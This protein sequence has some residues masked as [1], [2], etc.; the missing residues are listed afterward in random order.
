MRAV[1]IKISPFNPATNARVPV[2]LSSLNDKTLA[3]INAMGANIWVPCLTALPTLSIEVFNGDFQAAVQ[4]GNASF[5]FNIAMLAEGYPG[6][7]AMVW[8]RAP[9]EIY[10]EDV[11]AAL[12]WAPRFVGKVESFSLRGLTMTLGAK[13]DEEPFGVDVLTQTYAGTT[14]AEGPA[15]LK[16]KTK[17]LVIGWVQNVEPVLINATDSVYQF[18][19]YGPIEQVTTLYERGAAN[20]GAAVADYANYAALV[21]ASIPRGRWATCLAQGMIRLGAPAYGV[22]TADVKGHRVG[23]TTPRLSGQIISALASI[24]GVSSSLLHTSSLDAMDANKPYPAGLVLTE[25]TNLLDIAQTLALACNHQCG[26]SLL[27]QLFV[28]RPNLAASPALSVNANGSTWPQVA[29]CSEEATSAPYWRT[30]MGA[31]KSWRV[32]N[33]DEV[34]FAANLIP[35]G[36]YDDAET[37]R[38]GNIVDLPDGSR[39][40]YINTSPTAGNDP[41]TWPTASNAWWS[42]HTPPLNAS[43]LAYADGTPIEDLKPADP[44]ATAGADI[45]VDLR[46]PTSIPTAAELVTSLGTA[47]AIAG[48]GDM[49][50][51][52]RSTLAFGDNLVVNSEFALVDPTYS[53]GTTPVGWQP[54]WLG[55]STN[56]GAFTTNP[57]RVTLQDG[58][59]AYARDV[60]GT[61]NGTAMD[62]IS[63]YPTGLPLARFAVPVLPGERL[64]YSALLGYQ[65]CSGAYIVIGFYDENGNYVDE[66]GSTTITPNIGTAAYNTITRSSLVQSANVLTVP[67][68]GSGGGTGKRRWAVIWA[69]YNLNGSA[70]PRLLF[71]APMIAKVMAGQLAIPTY[72]PGPADR[73]ASYGATTGT[74]LVSPTYGNL[75]DSGI[76]TPIGT[77]AAIVG[78][79]PF[80]TTPLPV[81]RLTQIRPNLFPYPQ[82]VD[83]GRSSAAIG[84]FNTA[85]G[86]GFTDLIMG[87][88]SWTDGGYY[89]HYRSSGPAVNLFPFYDM[90]W[91]D[92]GGHVISAGLNGYASGGTFNPYVEFINAAKTTILG[93]AVMT[94]NSASDRWEVN[95]VTTPANTAFIRMVASAIFAATSVYQDVVFWS[96]KVERGPNATPCL[97]TPNQ[98]LSGDQIEWSTGGKLN[99]LRPDELGSNKTE[100]RVASAISGQTGWATYSGDTPSTYQLRVQYIDTSGQLSA[101]DR[102]VDRRMTLLRRADG[103]TALTEAMAITALGTA[104]AIVGQG[105]GA[106]AANLAAFDPTASAQL[107]TAYNGGA[108]TVGLGETLK[109]RL[110]AAA[111][112]D[113]SAQVSVDAGGSSS[114]NI[115]ARIEVSLFGAGSWSTVNTGPG[116]S[117]TP[118][119]PG[120]DE[121]TGT[122]TNSTG[123]E[124]L[125]EFRVVIVRTPGTA[126]G[127]LISAQS[128][129]VG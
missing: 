23:A 92:G 39:W 82:G 74:N 71:A 6:V 7:E 59:Y 99:A 102:V 129:I 60:T 68:D 81:A 76:Y 12:P 38:E 37:Y 93:S 26:V 125:F 67:A 100:T 75:S 56:T 9:V 91:N 124:Q 3:H 36:A 47:A 53:G 42:N 34:A 70:N 17:P 41:P 30:T 69:R 52:N 109:R 80:A 101:L 21:A 62:V 126:G 122:Y 55:N 51:Q 32:H 89:I 20:L 112:L 128:F 107:T 31:N 54:G 94:F 88:T 83:D 96:I 43:G 87:R 116:A 118:S 121:V 63:S 58:S 108:M 16:N 113:L 111:S 103:S 123:V 66:Y 10:G 95:G 79:G 86:N 65:G 106:T 77:A 13:V 19:A 61:P 57:R 1:L 85:P 84:W 11:G 114:G 25:Q 8:A 72:T 48:Q 29:E 22:I 15:D 110:G 104:A 120:L 50:T 28:T 2:Y 33:A 90:S 27:G 115:K 98:R 119:E 64:T 24:A 73:Q 4:T 49:A 46:L 117:V 18:S 78:Q 5:G 97:E 127:T 40:I 105:P 44:S 14:G 45:G 35:L